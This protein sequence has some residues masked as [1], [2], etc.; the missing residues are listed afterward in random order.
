MSKTSVQQLKQ[1]EKKILT[2]LQNNAHESID[3]LAK[4]C[5]FSRQKVWRIMKKLEKE[6][7]IWGYT[8]VYDQEH[9]NLKRFT[10][11]MKRSTVP[12]DKKVI[13][14]ILTTRLDDLL[15][16]AHIQ[17]ENIEYVHGSCD[18]I[19]TF[20]AQDIVTAKKFC[21]RFNAKFSPYVDNLEI[22]EHIL[23]IRK[24]TLRNPRLKEQ[25]KF[26]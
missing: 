6:R 3:V 19:F 25:I 24:Q 14:E 26:L 21:E 5:G 16:D 2:V 8:A 7:I 17:I 11:L 18:G 4:K 9:Y 23:G 22:L 1:D 15:P 10:M 20:L 13:D 12:L